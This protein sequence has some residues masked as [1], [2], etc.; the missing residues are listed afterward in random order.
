[1]DRIK[2]HMY[3]RAVFEC[4]MIYINETVKQNSPAL[5]LQMNIATAL[6]QQTLLWTTYPKSRGWHN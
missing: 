6:R 3:I 2:F 1:M 5:Y 4:K